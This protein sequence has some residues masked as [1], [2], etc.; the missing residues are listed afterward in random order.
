[1]IG[2]LAPVDY[3]ANGLW[4]ILVLYRLCLDGVFCEDVMIMEIRFKLDWF[5]KYCYY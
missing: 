5:L 1:M 3:V 2:L 4:I